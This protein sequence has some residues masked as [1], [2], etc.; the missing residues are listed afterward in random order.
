MKYFAQVLILNDSNFYTKEAQKRIRTYFTYFMYHFYIAI[1][2]NPT[3]NPSIILSLNSCCS[4][5]NTTKHLFA[6][7][8]QSATP[9]GTVEAPKLYT[10]LMLR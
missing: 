6:P 4:L 2:I 1:S 8:A 5:N 3:E 10:T 7:I 9:I